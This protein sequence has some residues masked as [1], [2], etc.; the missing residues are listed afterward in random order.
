MVSGRS[1][2]S[3]C[4]LLPLFCWK[5]PFRLQHCA[6]VGTAARAA[7]VRVRGVVSLLCTQRLSGEARSDLSTS[8]HLSRLSHGG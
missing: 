6:A 3:L 7:P 2:G 8:R 4:V 5:L 1:G